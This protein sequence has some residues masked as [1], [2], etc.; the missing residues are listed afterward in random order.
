MN[1][2]IAIMAIGAIVAGMA[3]CSESNLNASVVRREIPVIC[4]SQK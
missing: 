1:K 3:S 4:K 2:T